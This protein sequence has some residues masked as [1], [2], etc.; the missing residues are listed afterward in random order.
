VHDIAQ[1]LVMALESE[2]SGSVL[3]VGTGVSTSIRD[4]AR[5]LIHHMGVDVEPVFRPRAVLVSRRAADISRIREV[6]GWQPTI[7]VEG[8]LRTVVD[9][10]KAEFSR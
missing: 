4:L 3:N 1:S 10:F 2:V 9:E 6:L 5:M 8:G 7:D